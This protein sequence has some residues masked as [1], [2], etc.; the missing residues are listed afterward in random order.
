MKSTSI[1]EAIVS[2]TSDAV[3]TADRKGRIITWNAAAE[4]AFGRAATEVSGKSL[5][6]LMPE[7]FRDLHNAGISRVATTGKTKVT[8]QVLALIGLHKLGH[9]FPIELTLSTWELDG[10]RYF[11]GIIRDMS[12]QTKLLE[13]LSQ[14]EERMRAI[15]ESA[16]DAIICADTEGIVILWNRAAEDILG[17]SSD[18]MMGN[19]LTA[20][21]PERFRELHNIGIA[22]VGGGGERHVI[23]KTAELFALHKDGR[24]LPVELS[25]STWETAG[26]RYFSGII[27]DVTEHAKLIEA[28]G[29]S[30][31][32]MRSIMD[33]ANDAI[34]CADETGD[35]ILCNPAAETLLGRT[36]DE[37]FGQPLT[38]IIPERY[39]SAH[40]AGIERVRSGGSAHVIGRAV[41]L[42]A[43]HADGHELPIELSLGTWVAGGRRYF[44]GIIRDISMR[45]EAEAK[46]AVASKALDDKNQQLEA[47]SIKLAKYLSKQ[48]YNSIFTGKRDVRIESYRKKLTVFFSDIQGF[49]ELTDKMEAETISDLLN[50][51][52]SEMSKIAEKHGGTVDKFIGDGI[53]IFFGDPETFG[54]GQDAIACVTMALEMRERINELCSK[55]Q[56]QGAADPLHVRVGVNSGYCTV[57]NFG[58]DERMDYTIVGGQVNMT[59]RLET[60]AAADQILISHP[61]YSLVK[62]KIFCRPVGQIAVKGIARPI[63]TYEAVMTIDQ[64]MRDSETIEESGDAFNLSVD[65]NALDSDERERAKDSLIKA[66]AALGQETEE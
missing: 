40:S 49:T 59:S 12:H 1:L 21:I 55:W 37:L 41:E 44:S 5:T 30:E 57:G 53:M 54:E 61:T 23:G 8:G 24:E 58:S 43:L 56:E 27:R 6:L 33:S 20:I 60:A 19:P 31:E 29:R 9:E 51:Y 45:M 35:F 62:D 50:N 7:R 39:R 38:I 47:L 26:K 52:L 4:K 18:E 14:S 34:I 66:L 32:Q 2:S 15:M 63:K 65:I 28:L 10:E 13:D 17:F 16:N 46:I 64:H 22:R 3:V 42:Q 36:S 48:V 11:G 25:L